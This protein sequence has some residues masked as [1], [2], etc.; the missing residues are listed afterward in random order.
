MIEFVHKAI[1]ASYRGHS[2]AEEVVLKLQQ[3]G[4]PMNHLSIIGRDWKANEDV[5]GFYHSGDTVK[6]G[7]KK[8]TWFGGIFGLFMG[9]GM[10][11]FPMA[12]MLIVLGPLALPLR[13]RKSLPLPCAF[14]RET[15]ASSCCFLQADT[16][17]QDSDKTPTTPKEAD[18]LERRLK[19]HP[20]DFNTRMLLLEY[21]FWQMIQSPSAHVAHERHV[22]WVIRNHPDADIAGVP[23][24]SLV[25]GREDDAIAKAKRLWQ[26]QI[27]AHPKNAKLLGNAVT[28]FLK[29]GSETGLELLNRAQALEPKNP[30]WPMQ[31]GMIYS[32]WMNRSAGKQRQEAAKKAVLAWERWWM[33]IGDVN[34]DSFLDALPVAAFEAGDMGKAH[35][36]AAK[37]LEMAARPDKSAFGDAI[38]KGSLILGRIALKS[39]DIEKAKSFL[40]A[41]GQTPGSPVLDSFG[42][43]MML[44]KELLEK[45]ERQAVL[46]YFALC[47]KFWTMDDGAKIKQWTEEVKAGRIPDFGANLIY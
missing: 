1:V 34:E 32:E 39:G 10:F 2:G 25:H 18:K 11:M 12:G 46:D 13:S 26:Q 17:G 33:L 30:K 31:Q 24:M 44:A 47:A 7:T 16:P 8:G 23:A 40:L 37:L 20:D 45:G 35:L 15:I 29:Q 43:N 38:H 36:Y 14:S 6:E 41:S 19:Q 4:L 22:L 28:F 42:P 27:S 21:Y 3:S 5:E 9:M